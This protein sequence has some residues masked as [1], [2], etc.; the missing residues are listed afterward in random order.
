MGR[1]LC[2]AQYPGLRTYLPLGSVC[3]KLINEESKSCSSHQD[4]GNVS[5][6]HRRVGFLI[7]PGLL[8]LPCGKIFPEALLGAGDSKLLAGWMMLCNPGLAG[9][10]WTDEK[11][12]KKEFF[13]PLANLVDMA[14]SSLTGLQY[15][16]GSGRLIFTNL[17][18]NCL[19]SVTHTAWQCELLS[20][21][22]W[23]LEFGT[24]H[25]PSCIHSVY[26]EN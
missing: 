20:I 24:I 17:D 14:M 22:H 13:N 25:V 23:I 19:Y 21:S 6:S 5:Q 10:E 18:L 12:L 1:G 11:R 4:S 15:E 16:K 26:F 8:L 7:N 9:K 2:L 3:H